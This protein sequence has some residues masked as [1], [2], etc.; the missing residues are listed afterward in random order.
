MQTIIN[1]IFFNLLNIFARRTIRVILK[2]LKKDNWEL[3][4]FLAPTTS[5][6]LFVGETIS[7]IAKHIIIVSK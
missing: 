4:D 7:T 2:T 6:S 3:T 5:V 1:L